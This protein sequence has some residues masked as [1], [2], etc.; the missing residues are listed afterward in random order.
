MSRLFY[1]P[2]WFYWTAFI[3]C[4]IVALS[5]QTVGG[6]EVSSAYNHSDLNHGVRVIQAG[7]AFQFSNTVMFVLLVL[8]TNFRLQKKGPTIISTAGWPAM[9]VM[10]VSTLMLLIRNGYRIF[11]LS[12]GWHGR[13]L[14]TQGY[15][16]G[17]DMA[18]MAVAVAAFILLSP[19]LFFRPGQS[20][21]RSTVNNSA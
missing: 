11:E 16:I 3:V 10:C 9:V 6:V 8:A 1:M 4:D 15:L 19:C 7:V 12:A 13:L 14:R 20:R 2:S 17:L 18:P 21:P 5:I